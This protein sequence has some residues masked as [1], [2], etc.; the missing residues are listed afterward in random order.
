MQAVFS[1]LL[2]RSLTHARIF[3]LSLFLICLASTLRSLQLDNRIVAMWLTQFNAIAY[4]YSIFLSLSCS[5]SHFL[6]R[7]LHYQCNNSEIKLSSQGKRMD[8]EWI[9]WNILPRA[10]IF[11]A[12]QIA[13]LV[14]DSN[15]DNIQRKSLIRRTS[16]EREF[17]RGRSRV[18]EKSIIS[19]TQFLHT[20]QNCI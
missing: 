13:R 6:S 15:I 1:H 10:E 9:T 14:C 19:L 11:S 7:F 8:R 12:T 5:L 17:Y 16:H 18:H 3:S 20:R 4:K 2:V